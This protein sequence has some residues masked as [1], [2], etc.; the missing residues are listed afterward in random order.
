MIHKRT[1]LHLIK[2]THKP[3]LIFLNQ[4]FYFHYES[5]WLKNVNDIVCV[6]SIGAAIAVKLCCPCVLVHKYEF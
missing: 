6:S 3:S 1:L 5:Y 2:T 4:I